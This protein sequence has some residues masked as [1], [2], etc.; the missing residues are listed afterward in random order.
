MHSSS[1]HIIAICLLHIYTH[2]YYYTSASYNSQ[3]SYL[4]VLDHRH[5]NKQLHR[6]NEFLQLHFLVYTLFCT[7]KAKIHQS[8]V[9]LDINNN[10][11]TF[12][13]KMW[14]FRAMQSVSLYLIGEPEP[15]QIY[16]FF[17]SLIQFKARTKTIYMKDNNGCHLVIQYIVTIKT[18]RM[19][20][21]SKKKTF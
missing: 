6:L 7:D 4:L 17:A 3:Y 2:K 1:L 19:K 18:F 21:Q 9:R 10:G 14:Y 20:Q 11:E 13:Y 8:C 12:N 5:Y 15:L 16:L